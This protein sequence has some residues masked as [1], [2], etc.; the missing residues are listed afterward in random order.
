MEVRSYSLPCGHL[1]AQ[2]GEVI[3]PRLSEWRENWALDIEIDAI[4]DVAHVRNCSNPIRLQPALRLETEQEAAWAVVGID[5]VALDRLGAAVLQRS[6]P[7]PNQEASSPFLSELGVQVLLELAS[8]FNPRQPTYRPAQRGTLAE[9]LD[10]SLRGDLRCVGFELSIQGESVKFLL[11]WSLAELFITS[12]IDASIAAQPAVP[13]TPRLNS[14]T[15]ESVT[16]EACLGS[17]EI[18]LDALGS[19]RIGDVLCLDT[20]LDQ[21][22]SLNFPGSQGRFSGFLGR[23][24][25]LLAL[26]IENFIPT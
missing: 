4:V 2:L 3:A 12:F 1:V 6:I 20:G 14:L 25:Q 11:P 18:T 16:A 26:R 10:L 9:C 19:L 22:L 13:L 7:V 8:R 21:P 24:A 17:V 23:Q 5:E 15:R